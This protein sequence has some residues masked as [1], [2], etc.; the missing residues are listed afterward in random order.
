MLA[1]SALCA[2]SSVPPKAQPPLLV[3]QPPLPVLP[4]PQPIRAESVQ[5]RVVEVDGVPLFALTARGYE[6]LSRNIADMIRWA[7][8]A[9][10]QI[11]FY[12]EQRKPAAPTGG[13]K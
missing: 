8:E 5:W 9:S 12:R 2:C 4:R 10:W 3:D 1:L 13:S 6:A 7:G 11:D